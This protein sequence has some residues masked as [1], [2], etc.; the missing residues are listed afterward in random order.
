MKLLTIS[1]AAYN[2]E[3]YIRKTLESLC[4]KNVSQ[5]EVFVIDDGGNDGT[6]EIAKEFEQKYPNVFYAI[7]KE[8]GGLGSTYNY[9]IQHATGKYLKLLDGDD[10]FD[11]NELDHLINFLGI[12]D[13]DVVYTPYLT[14]DDETGKILEHHNSVSYTRYQNMLMN[15]EELN[16][17]KDLVMHS[18]MFKSELLK[19][20][21]VSITEKCFY[22]DT[23]F[24]SKALF[25]SNT[26]W[27]TE[28]EVYQYRLGR[29]GQSVDIN[30][31]RKHYRESVKVCEEL[32][33]FCNKN[34]NDKNQPILLYN[35]SMMMD[36]VYH[37][38]LILRKKEDFVSF[39]RELKCF[40]VKHNLNVRN[41]VKFL[42]LLGYSMFNIVSSY[43]ANK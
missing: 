25:Y 40:Q 7:H 13:A 29:E 12:T 41:Y 17:Y 28:Y 26:I 15:L 34:E 36:F 24:V 14:F 39:D 18:T 6:L 8:N 4:C 16:T 11:T 3:K 43:L 42:R 9:S 5:I 33:S 27:F 38:L 10:Y 19:K 30:G 20:G 35:I 1:V 21:E 22:T 32:I 23:E 31:L 37:T 2:A